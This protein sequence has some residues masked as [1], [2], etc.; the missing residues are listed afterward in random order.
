M[1]QT[2]RGYPPIELRTQND[3]A[4]GRVGYWLNLVDRFGPRRGRVIEVG[5]AHGAL[6]AKLRSHG[7]ECIGVEPDPET[8]EWV[9]NDKGLDIRAGLFPD[10]ELPNCDLFLAFDVWEH[11]PDPLAFLQGAS[12]LL[13]AGG[14]AIIQTPIDR[15]R[16]EP[17]FGDKFRPAFEDTEHLFLFTDT[18]VER[19][20]ERS[21][22]V[23]VDATERLW[24]HHE[25]CVLAKRGDSLVQGLE[26]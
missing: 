16:T 12:K 20:A 11:G 25:V 4:D 17:P 22:L 13:N 24:L 15:Y 21:G 26:V 23:V 9:R 7:Y 19:L 1:K 18:A 2:V 3:L 10:V 14:I 6:L 8:A 5:C